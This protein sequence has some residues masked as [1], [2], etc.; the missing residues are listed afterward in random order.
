MWQLS[1]DSVAEAHRVTVKY[2]CIDRERRWF[3]GGAYVA[4]I[5]KKERE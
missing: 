1:K 4:N 3:E 2:T 5:R